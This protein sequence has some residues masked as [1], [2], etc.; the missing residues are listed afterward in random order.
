MTSMDDLIRSKEVLE[1]AISI[2][3]ENEELKKKLIEQEK[4]KELNK[5]KEEEKQKKLQVLEPVNYDE[6]Y[7]KIQ[8]KSRWYNPLSWG[9]GD[10]TNPIVMVI[11]SP[12]GDLTIRERVADQRG[13]LKLGKNTLYRIEHNEIWDIAESEIKGFRGKRILF[14]FQDVANPI[15]IRRDDT[16]NKI[17]IN[18]ETYAKSQKTH[19]VSELLQPE[20][21]FTDYI[22]MIIVGVNVILTLIIIFKIWFGGGGGS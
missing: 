21:K 14:Y 11:L 8:E 20:V 12:A 3:K 1:K 4:L 2:Q 9:K 19:L 18:T 7:F 6:R 22:T 13:N 10:K 15:R 16:Q 5:K 17:T